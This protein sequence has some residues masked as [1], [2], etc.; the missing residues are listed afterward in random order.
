MKKMQLDIEM[1][2]HTCLLIKQGVIWNGLHLLPSSDQ[3]FPCS[4]TFGYMNYLQVWFFNRVTTERQTESDAYEQT[5]HMHKHRC[6]Q[7][8]GAQYK[9]FLVICF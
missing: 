5:V 4:N 2:E 9:Q 8:V 3:A 7:K 1:S 6:A